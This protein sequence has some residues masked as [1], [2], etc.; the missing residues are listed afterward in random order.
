MSLMGAGLMV[1]AQRKMDGAQYKERNRSPPTWPCSCS[2]RPE[3]HPWASPC[4]HPST[5]VQA[6]GSWQH[7]TGEA[8]GTQNPQL[9]PSGAKLCRSAVFVGTVTNQRDDSLRTAPHATLRTPTMLTPDI[10]VPC[11]AHT[12]PQREESAAIKSWRLSDPS[13]EQA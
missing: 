1:V 5:A 7:A 2:S 9:S 4:A 10:A 6:I 3:S 12:K 8:P 11:C 13:G